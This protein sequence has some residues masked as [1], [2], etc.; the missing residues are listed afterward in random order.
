VNIP[1]Y[2][3]ES[4]LGRGGMGVVY[5][6]RQLRLHRTVAL[7][8]IVAGQF[9]NSELRKRF[10][11]EAEA[12]ARLQHPNIVQL[13]ESGLCEGRPYFSLE[14]VDGSS[15][16]QRLHGTPIEP[17]PAAKLVETLALAMQAAHERGIVHRD[18]KPANILIVGSPGQPA[19]E[20]VPKI[21]DFGLAKQ[22]DETSHQT[23]SGDVLGTP[24][25]MA[26]EQAS[27]E[28]G[29]IG[30]PTDIYAL[31]AVLYELLTGHPPFSAPSIYETIAKVINSEPLSIR[32]LQEAVPRDLETICLKCL[33]KSPARRYASA[34]ELAED[35]KRFRHHEPIRA[36]PIGFGER[37]AKWA[38]RKPAAAALWLGTIS[39]VIFGLIGAIAYESRVQTT[40]MKVQAAGLVRSLAEAETAA[41]PRL[42]EE[43]DEVRDWANPLLMDLA[44]QSEPKSKARLHASMALLLSDSSQAD[45]LGE[46]LLSAELASIAPLREI[47][48]PFASQVERKCWHA[49]SDPRGAEGARLR[50]ACALALWRSEDPR[51]PKVADR[52][53]D[54]MLA[55][56]KK[57]PADFAPLTKDL[58]PVSDALIPSL[59]IAFS[60]PKREDFERFM[61]AHML[62]EFASNRPAVLA[63]LLLNSDAK[64]FAVLFDGFI[65]HREV[66]V[67][68]LTN[69][70]AETSATDSDREKLAKRQ[71]NAAAALIA[72]R[73]PDP[74]WPLLRASEDNRLRSY[75]IHRIGP[76]GGDF[77]LVAR[78][79]REETDVTAQAALML[80]LGAFETPAAD[81]VRQQTCAFVKDVYRT[82][83]D[84]GLHAAAEWLLRRWEEEPFIAE[85][86][87]RWV[88]DSTARHE[89]IGKIERQFRESTG[90]RKP[91]WYLNGQGQ[92]MVCIP[93]PISF[94]MGS[95]AT[96]AGRFQPEELHPMK[97]N[98]SFAIGAKSVTVAQFKQ[99][100]PQH[101]FTARYAPT[102][103]CPVITI[104][105]LNAAA[106]CNWLS[107]QEGIPPDQWCYETDAEGKVVRMKD[108]FLRLAGYRLPTDAEMEFASRAG[109]KTSRYFGETDELLPHYG[110]YV[111]NSE[112]RTQPVGMKKPNDLGLFDVYG[113]VWNWCQ[114]IVTKT[115]RPTID[116]EQAIE[117][118]LQEN[119]IL[120]GGCFV[121]RPWN[122]R[123]ANFDWSAPTLQNIFYGFR[124]AKTLAP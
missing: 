96:E 23:Q 60:D 61:T 50:A 71:A 104:S 115:N 123:S 37:L 72:L 12:V 86:H 45:Y 64:Q 107:E 65:R 91:Q 43:L 10:E 39:V 3:I 57:N 79:L 5:K 41:V 121:V 100:K 32:R 2:A 76:F 92:T 40:R 67:K 7:K 26:P 54:P 119:R 9:A 51:W 81:S 16:A 34:A 102:P 66:G 52:L 83:D 120:R 108:G 1:G 20:W 109:T 22:L 28:V 46:R 29:L 70:L 59:S 118:D 33:Q 14:F 99:F 124:V 36:R 56:I 114:D 111:N 13:F 77:E 25:Y 49:V 4:E 63:D 18:L 30:P 42:I 90:E 122:M 38:R 101:K 35:L 44:K 73:V 85:T 117:I 112:D 74:V 21:A 55:A 19:S 75:V 47:L 68:K 113:N 24:S 110:W 53:V 89:R 48:R 106:Y 87:Q 88:K 80:C 105:W 82:S 94:R 98:R 97:I 116:Q 103:D 95:P 84:P 62:A 15:L 93:G 31:G 58:A 69:V 78:R 11:R 6:A 17:A 27:G 8:M